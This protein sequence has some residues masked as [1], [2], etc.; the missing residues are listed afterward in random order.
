[1]FQPLCDSPNVAY[2]NPSGGTDPVASCSTSMRGYEGF[3]KGKNF[4]TKY[5]LTKL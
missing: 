1:V 2:H 4:L 5:D 3:Q